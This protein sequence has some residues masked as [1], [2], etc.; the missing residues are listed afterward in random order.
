MQT[1][2]PYSD[3]EKVAKCLDTSRLYKQ[4]VECKQLLKA[5]ENRKQGFRYVCKGEYKHKYATKLSQCLVCG[6]KIKR[7]GWIDH[8]C[9][10]MWQDYP[11]ALRYYQWCMFKEWTRKRWNW[12]ITNG[13]Y[14]YGFDIFKN[15]YKNTS[16]M[17]IDTINTSHKMI[18]PKWLGNEELHRS[19]RLN[20]LFKNPEHYS[21]Y[22]K[23]EIPKTKPDYVWIK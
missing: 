14:L 9:T 3:F 1:F 11:E 19:H 6:S 17:I 15:K 4:I 7:I 23:E 13:E 2:L 5:I 16:P 22:F 21:K 20:L 18:Y 10:I 8:S 12:D